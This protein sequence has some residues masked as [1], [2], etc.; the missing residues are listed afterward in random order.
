MRADDL[1]PTPSTP[2][3]RLQT[4][5]AAYSRYAE[6][7]QEQLRALQEENLDRFI[8]LADRRGAIQEEM[9]AGSGAIP[10][11][12][13]LDPEEGQRLGGA[14]EALGRALAQDREIEARVLRLRA[15]VGGQIR[16]LSERN[17]NAKQYVTESERSSE[18]R[19]HRLNVRL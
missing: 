19:P 9:E 15:E 12:V 2:Q 5:L 16:A 7:V 13:G 14:K 6:I 18:D 8:E 4:R 11:D 10:H 1:Q 3:D 17:G